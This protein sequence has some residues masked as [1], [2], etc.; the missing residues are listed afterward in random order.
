MFELQWRRN[1]G[2]LLN[3]QV[4]KHRDLEF[5]SFFQSFMRFETFLAFLCFAL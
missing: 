2:E 4:E 3:R 1:E 5:Q